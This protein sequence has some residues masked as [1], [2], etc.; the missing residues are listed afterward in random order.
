MSDS[1]LL[2]MAQSRPRDPDGPSPTEVEEA[3]SRLDL[4]APVVERL[5]S[6]TR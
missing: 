3:K 6:L 4:Y 1:Q 5:R 2:E